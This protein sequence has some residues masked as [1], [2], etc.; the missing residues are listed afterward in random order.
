MEYDVIYADPPWKFSSRG[1]RGGRYGELDYPTMTK[2]EL[3]AM[4]VQ[5]V[6]AENCALFMWSTSAHMPHALEIGEAWGFKYV[7]ID[8]I[9]VKDR[10]VVGPWGMSD[11]E[12]MLLFVKGK[13]CSEQAVRNQ[14]QAYTASRD[15]KHSEKPSL[16]RDLIEE[17]FPDARKL[18]MFAR[19]VPEGW[20]VFGN[21]VENS[22]HIY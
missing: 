1:A 14:K 20:D 13:M 22:I 5:D 7:R 16:F 15:G 2:K 8:K 6:V 12:P 4:R 3:M 21:E 9:W 19:Q 11:M 17:R 10:P 18:E